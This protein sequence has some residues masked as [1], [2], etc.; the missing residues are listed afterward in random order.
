VKFWLWL[1]ALCSVWLGCLPSA[2]AEARVHALIIGSNQA[3]FSDGAKLDTALPALHY[4]DDDAAAFHEFIAPIAASLELLTVLDRETQALYPDLASRAGVPTLEAV[5]RAVAALKQRILASQSRRDRQVVFVFFSGHGALGDDGRPALGLFDGGLTQDFLY[6]EILAQLP[7]DELHLLVDACHA[8]AIVRPRDAAPQLEARIVPISVDRA[9]QF[10]VQTTLTRFP[11]VGAIVAASTDNKAHEW[12]RLR[13]G[14]FTH[15]LLSAL[16]GAA[17]VNRDRRLEYSEV[18]A[19]MSA[20]NREVADVRA[21]LSVVAKPPETNRRVA[22]V[23]LSQFPPVRLA[24]LSGVP[25]SDQVV[26]ISDERGRRLATLHGARDFHA[27]LLLPA[28]SRIYVR[29]GDREASFRAT[30]GE[31]VPF[32]GLEFTSA[33]LRERSPLDDAIRRGLF[34]AAYGRSYYDGVVDQM[35]G[36]IPVDFAEPR[37]SSSLEYWAADH[38][39]TALSAHQLVAGVGISAGIADLVPLTHGVNIGL[40]PDTRSGP[41]GSLRVL[42]AADGP[43]REWHLSANVGWAWSVAY[44]PTRAWAGGS[45]SA[46]VLTQLIEEQASRSSLEL[47]AGPLLGLTTSIS[48]NFGLW[49]ELELSGVLHRRDD[50]SVLSWFPSAWLGAS[51]RL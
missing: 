47:G 20:A 26:E 21:R 2:R 14:I 3:H 22:L 51:F 4:A 29:G 27:D 41:L 11:H 8:E 28:Q 7:A 13:H 36:F 23:S 18:Y 34:A 44:G 25:G 48:S 15:E 45:L 32:A 24:W 6:H 38:T 9:N 42:S 17:D 5:K 31:I 39:R 12:D 43:L 19:F 40:R 46:G 35:S 30:S 37:D 16:R 50:R 10:L 33:A 49:S 1:A